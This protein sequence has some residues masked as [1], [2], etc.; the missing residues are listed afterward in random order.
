MMM[1]TMICA[2][3][4]AAAVSDANAQQV[5]SSFFGPGSGARIT[6]FDG[7]PNGANFPGAASLTFDH[8]SFSDDKNFTN[9]D[10]RGVFVGPYD[11]AR[12][13]YALG[14]YY[15]GDGIAVTLGGTDSAVGAWV[16]GYLPGWAISADFYDATSNL[17][18]VTTVVGRTS[19][20]LFL[21]YQ[22]TGSA[23]AKVVFND[24][25]LNGRVITI[26]DFSTIGPNTGV[27]EPGMWAMML[28]GFGAFGVMTRRARRRQTGQGSVVAA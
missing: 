5:G 27:P 19:T 26:D 1:K 4:L 25:S 20:M 6:T 8:N 7:V 2:A 9:S 16:S 14:S 3:L 12:S 13:G 28:A 21:G 18:G 11:D 24:L 15:D 23:I 17:L 22:S 10:T